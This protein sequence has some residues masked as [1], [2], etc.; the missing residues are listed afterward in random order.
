MTARP[1]GSE[2]FR[3]TG[4]GSAA[5]NEPKP[6]TLKEK[7]VRRRLLVACAALVPL[8]SFPG[9]PDASAGPSTGGKTIQPATQADPNSSICETPSSARVLNPTD[10]TEIT[11][12]ARGREQIRLLKSGAREQNVSIFDT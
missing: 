2:P 4:A 8:F 11:K 7:S 6:L 12:T 10:F 3:W 5:S 1:K 9:V